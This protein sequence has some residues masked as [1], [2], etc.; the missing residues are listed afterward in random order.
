MTGTAKV[1]V[2]S[3]TASSDTHTKTVT[4]NNL[5]GALPTPTR[6][7]YTFAGWYTAASGGNQVTSGTTVS[8]ASNHTLYAHWNKV[9]TAVG[10]V[11]NGSNTS[12]AANPYGFN[13]TIIKC[14]PGATATMQMRESFIHSGTNNGHS[15]S[16]TISYKSYMGSDATLSNVNNITN[17]VTFTMPEEDVILYFEYVVTSVSSN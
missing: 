8:T 14:S 6:T 7:G 13:G 17:G 12:V 16:Q 3:S 15:Y 5:Y 4:Y 9:Y 2:D 11:T 1:Y 10:L